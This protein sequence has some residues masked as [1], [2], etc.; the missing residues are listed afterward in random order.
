MEMGTENS[1]QAFFPEVFLR[2]KTLQK[3]IFHKFIL[4]F[5]RR[6][7]RQKREIANLTILKDTVSR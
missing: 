3:K 1:K 7:N 2:R 5:F 4:Q 6:V